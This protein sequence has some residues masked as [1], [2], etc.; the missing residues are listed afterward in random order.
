MNAPRWSRPLAVILGILAGTIATTGTIAVAAAAF[1][2]SFDAIRDVAIW[3]H[4]RADWAWMLPVAV[5]G[6]MATATV[7]AVVLHRLRR[8]TLYPWAVVLTGAGISI[9]CNALHAW[10]GGGA[11]ALPRT[12]AM[13]VSAVPP[14]LLALSIHLLVMLVDAASQRMTHPATTDTTPPPADGD[15]APHG[16]QRLAVDEWPVDLLRRIPVKPDRYQRWRTAWA[17][18]QTDTDPA[19]VA[20]RHGYDLRTIQFVR[21]A[22][23][24]GLLTSPTPPAARLAEL[25][26]G[27]GHPT[28]V[29]EPAASDTPNS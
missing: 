4:I 25:A 27:N 14:V 23:Q 8:R 9:A 19:Q 13:A 3:S 24:A 6:A 15:P 28:Q 22:G 7:T 1:T 2:L 18:L 16:D 12:V 29:A 20:T 17:D 26:A 5:D 10:A 11:L 21:R